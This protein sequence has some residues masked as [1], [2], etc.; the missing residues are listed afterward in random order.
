MIEALIIIAYLICLTGIITL[1][2]FY[3]KEKNKTQYFQRALDAK[4]RRHDTDVTE[5]ITLSKKQLETAFDAITDLICAL[6]ADLRIT[7]VNKSYAAFVEIPIPKLLGRYC[8]EVF[9]KRAEPCDNCPAQRTFATHK[10]VLKHQITMPDPERPRHFTIAT[11]PVFDAAGKTQNVIEHTR[12]STE[13][14]VILEQLIRSEKLASIGTMTAGIAHEMINPLS[15]IS[16]T[17]A[18]MLA[19]PGKYGLN[20]KGA[21]RVTTILES[22]SR[23]S[24]I[25]KDLLH[26]SRKEDGAS[27]PTDANSLVMKAVEAV[28]LKA[29]SLVE[30]TINLDKSI[31]PV[32]C[33]P[34]K[35]QQVIINLVTNATQSVQ[36]K[37]AAMA[38]DNRKFSG[39][40]I[41]A[42]R[43]Q[44]GMVRID[45]SDNGTG[46]PDAIRGRIFDPF[47]TTRPPGEGTGL[48]LSI[49]Q[50][51]I[52]EH[53]GR[54]FFKSTK[55]LTTFSILLPSISKGGARE[56]EP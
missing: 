32:L 29:T 52:D 30:Q 27:A 49:C 34:T 26:L 28:R 21:A 48:G 2:F 15:G 6:D 14:K 18:N 10:P 19:M 38:R 3:K 46:V 45:V 17:A 16:G 56:G 23:A 13:E 9:W 20:D 11:Y 36:E 54:I 47:F 25:V 24:A 39:L 41:I 37:R 42:T 50:K 53:Q 5:K 33:D 43:K 55:S 51:I 31:P 1:F 22:S 40:I 4:N 12:D 8:W 7:R 35:I 44:D